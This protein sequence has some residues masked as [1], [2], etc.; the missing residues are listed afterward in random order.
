MI[1]HGDGLPQFAGDGTRPDSS[2]ISSGTFD[3][4]DSDPAMN[5]LLEKNIEMMNR[6]MNMEFSIPMYGNNGL[7]KKI[8]K[9]QDY[10]RGTKTGRG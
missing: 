8:K 1:Y 9:A 3:V 4:G 7:V 2:M 10:E 6:L 5:R